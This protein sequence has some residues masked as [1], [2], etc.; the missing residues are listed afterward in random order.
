LYLLFDIPHGE[1]DALALFIHIQHGDFDHIAHRH[2][3][4]GVLDELITDLGDMHQTVLMDTDIHKHTEVDDI[5]D[6]AGKHH[7]G[8]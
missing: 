4:G 7:A 2:H 6:R 1:A 3:L 8:L 5:A